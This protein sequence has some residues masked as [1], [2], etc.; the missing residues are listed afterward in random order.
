VH[1]I[2]EAWIGK[3]WIVEVTASGSRAG[4]PFRATHLFL[5]SLHTTPEALLQ[6]VGDR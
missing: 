3:N 5:T 4:K 6:L 1:I 2:R